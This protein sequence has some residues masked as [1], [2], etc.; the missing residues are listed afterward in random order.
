[1]TL[2]E[3]VAEGRTVD[4]TAELL[5]VAPRTIRRWIGQEGLK[6][7][8]LRSRLVGRLRRIH[9]ADLEEFLAASNAA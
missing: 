5:G 4:E 3:A 8:I 7:R 9:P 2:T 1:V 6:G